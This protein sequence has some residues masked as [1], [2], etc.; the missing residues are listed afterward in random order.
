MPPSRW[1]PARL[2]CWLPAVAL[3]MIGGDIAVP[4]SERAALLGFGW[5]RALLVMPLLGVGLYFLLRHALRP[6]LGAWSWLAGWL[7]ASALMP[8]PFWVVSLNTH[9]FHLS[10]PLNQADHEA[11]RREFSA[12]YLHYSTSGDGPCLLIRKPADLEALR[13]F[14]GRQGL[15]PVP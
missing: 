14:L 6:R 5:S 10:R 11:L 4:E 15:A 3:L 7:V 13:S 8:L 2:A 12:R 9:T 1:S